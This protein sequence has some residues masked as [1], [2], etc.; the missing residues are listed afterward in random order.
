MMK[1]PQNPPP[2]LTLPATAVKNK[3]GITEA[4][5]QF[6]EVSPHHFFWMGAS[7]NEE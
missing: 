6:L 3:M 2:D 7:A 5:F 4:V 1:S